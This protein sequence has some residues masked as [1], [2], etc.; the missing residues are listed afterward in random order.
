[1]VS[2]VHRYHIEPHHLS[3]LCCSM[4]LGFPLGS[5]DFC[6]VPCFEG[7]FEFSIRFRDLR[8]QFLLCFRV[9]SG[10]FH[11]GGDDLCIDNE[12]GGR[13]QGLVVDCVFVVG[14]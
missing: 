8:D 10:S 6:R 3:L 11:A 5:V 4:L 7:D 12:C 9:E 13:C 14:D 1:M 2:A